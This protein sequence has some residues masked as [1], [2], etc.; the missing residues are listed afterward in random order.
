MEAV[1]HITD[2]NA[3]WD[4]VLRSAKE[5]VGADAA[6]LIMFNGQ[7]DLLLLKQIGVDESAEKEYTEHYYKDDAIAQAALTSP[8]GRWWDS[9]ALQAQPESRKLP[10]YVDYMPRHR[11]GQVLAFVIV[12]EPERRAAISFQRMTPEPLAVEKLH[13][14]KVGTYVR[15]LSSAIAAREKTASS[16]YDSVENALS[17]LGDA[18]FLAGTNGKL[19]RCS[20]KSYEL[21]SNAHMLSQRE[22]ALTHPDS[23]VITG[24]LAALRNAATGQKRTQFSIS[25]SWGQGLR[26][27]IAPAPAAFMLANE[28]VLLV[29]VQHSNAF[30]AADIEQL[31]SYFAVSRAEAK[32]LAALID[33][34]S[35]QEHAKLEGIAERTVRNHIASLMK[36]MSC[37][38]QAELVRL[39]SLLR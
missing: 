2:A 6:T 11:M 21:L 24:F 16:K 39:G 23:G 36:K 14:G 28:Q 32:V 20:S 18:I 27:D 35:P 12:G 4:E 31:I 8:S 26:F 5:V 10:F 3:P 13:R 7:Q 25:T 15:A 19:Y 17:S 33:G 9:S 30:V 1:S 29:R 38:R 37:T 34:H 22:R